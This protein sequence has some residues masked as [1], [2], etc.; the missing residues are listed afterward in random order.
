[1]NH[2]IRSLSLFTVRS[3]LCFAPGAALSGVVSGQTSPDCQLRAT[4]PPLATFGGPATAAPGETELALGVGAY[5]EGFGPACYADL[6]GATDWF[7]RWRR[8]VGSRIDLGFDALIDDRSDGT[9]AGTA[10]VAMRYKVKRGFRL[11]GGVGAADSGDGRSVNADAAAEIGTEHEDRTWNY[12]ASL[13]LAASHGCVN[14][15]CA[16]AST[17]DG[18]PPGAV[19]PLGVIGATARVSDNVQF[20]MEGGLGEYFSRVQSTH[21]M[22]IHISV[23]VLFEA[24]RNRHRVDTTS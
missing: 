10:K 1:M 24:R 7:V 14:L 8:G 13:R 16:P 21:G 23:G 9:L 2:E 6:V 18:R 5:G 17:T 12:Y 19:I 20:V 4:P 15:F 11:E 3:I 22:Y